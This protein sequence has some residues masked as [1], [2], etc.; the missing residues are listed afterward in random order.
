MPYF[1]FG[2]AYFATIRRKAYQKIKCLGPNEDYSF[3]ITVW[4]MTTVNFTNHFA[5]NLSDPCHPEFHSILQMSNAY[6]YIAYR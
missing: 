5:G 3:N 4:L 1:N 2:W 6:R